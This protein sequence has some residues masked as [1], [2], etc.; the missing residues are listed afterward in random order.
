M[1][2]TLKMAVVSGPRIRRAKLLKSL[3]ALYSLD[4]YDRLLLR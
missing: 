4:L 1:N 2:F 3:Q